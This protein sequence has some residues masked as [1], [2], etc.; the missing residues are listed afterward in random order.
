MQSS[1]IDTASEI[2][3]EEYLANPVWIALNETPPA[4][5]ER[6]EGGARYRPEFAPFGAA[7]NY[8]AQS[9]SQVAA[10]LRPG[11]RLSFFTAGKLDLP[12]GFDVVREAVVNQMVAANSFTVSSDER[13]VRLGI[14]DAPDML[15]LA[16][17]TEPGPFNARTNE[18]GHFFGIREG[19]QLVA[20]AGERMTAGK[21]VEISAVCT[22]PEWRGRG[23]GRLLMEHLS[24]TIQERN[25]V[26][27]LHVFTNN[28]SAVRL[29]RELGF[30]IA[31]TLQLTAIVRSSRDAR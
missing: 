8:S 4:V 31:R 2:A 15:R 28:F 11:Q 1:H 17:L 16:E 9:V 7:Q 19:G 20:M 30:R 23:L 13:I 6:G 21:Y 27:F 18:L 22:H 5:V 10:M 26:P 3:T 24:A 25:K 14:D 12:P 29:Y